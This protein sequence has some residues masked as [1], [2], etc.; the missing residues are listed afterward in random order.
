MKVWNMTVSKVADGVYEVKS[1]EEE[2]TVIEDINGEFVCTCAGYWYNG[3]CK[4]IEAVKIYREK[5]E[6]K[7]GK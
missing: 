5:Y 3:S 1:G 6:G 2:Y 7:E 4:H